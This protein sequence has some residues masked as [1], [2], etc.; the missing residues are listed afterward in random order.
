VLIIAGSHCLAEI[1]GQ[2]ASVLVRCR[3]AVFR[4]TISVMAG[5]THYAGQ[6]EMLDDRLGA[7]VHSFDDFYL[8]LLI[9]KRIAH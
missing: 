7:L 4:C 3:D 8:F 1:N 6:P 9:S 2:L 5:F